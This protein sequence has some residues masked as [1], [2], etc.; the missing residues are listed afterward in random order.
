MELG[1]KSTK[2]RRS[3][4]LKQSSQSVQFSKPVMVFFL[5]SSLKEFFIPS[6]S[7]SVMSVNLG[8]SQGSN[9]M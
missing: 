1:L 3:C 9:S 4:I 5:S 8:A 6:F 7:V 2:N